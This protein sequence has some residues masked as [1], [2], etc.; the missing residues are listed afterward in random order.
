MEWANY[1]S[2]LQAHLATNERLAERLI[3]DLGLPGPPAMAPLKLNERE[4]LRWRELVVEAEEVARQHREA[5]DSYLARH[6][7]LKR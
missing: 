5:L 7:Q 3:A 1:R 4:A 6:G 2:A